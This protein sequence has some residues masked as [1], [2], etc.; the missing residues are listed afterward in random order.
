MFITDIDN[1]DNTTTYNVRPG[2]L[3]LI[4]DIDYEISGSND[5]TIQNNDTVMMI[6]TL[7]GG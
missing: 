1:I 7:H 4:N 3:V 2:I 5:S 6:S